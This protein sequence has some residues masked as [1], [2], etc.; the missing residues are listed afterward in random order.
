MAGHY[1]CEIRGGGYRYKAEE[2]WIDGLPSN[3]SYNWPYI[4]N[5]YM[6][7]VKSYYSK[8]CAWLGSVYIPSFVAIRSSAVDKTLTMRCCFH[9]KIRIFLMLNV[10]L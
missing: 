9:C 1:K 5:R 7:G 6:K 10:W 2:S 3:F 4:G 8:R